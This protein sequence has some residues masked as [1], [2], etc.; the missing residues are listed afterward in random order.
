MERR[1]RKRGKTPIVN[2]QLIEIASNAERQQL[3]IDGAIGQILEGIAKVDAELVESILQAS[4]PMARLKR[5]LNQVASQL[6]PGCGSDDLVEA[7]DAL[8]YAIAPG[9]KPLPSG[10]VAKLFRI[11]SALPR[12][13][14][15]KLFK[16]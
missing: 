1:T 10:E 12:S 3:E 6:P 9:L 4:S 5:V 14:V 2:E 15:A 11:P 16:F 7:L 13:E 8:K